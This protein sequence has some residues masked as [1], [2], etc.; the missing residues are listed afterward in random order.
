MGFRDIVIRFPFLHFREPSDSK[1]P[2]IT[3]PPLADNAHIV[4]SRRDIRRRRHPEGMRRRILLGFP[5]ELNVRRG[6]V[7]I[8]RLQTGMGKEQSLRLIQIGPGHFHHRRHR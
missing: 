3:H 5:L 2:R 8:L 6:G 4:D 7:D 1:G